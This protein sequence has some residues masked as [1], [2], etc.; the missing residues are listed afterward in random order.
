MQLSN[1]YLE[2][3]I[4]SKYDQELPQSQTNLW[5]HMEETQ[6]INSHTTARTQ[7]KAT[8]SLPQPGIILGWAWSILWENY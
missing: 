4:K 8:I 5:H 6:N 2:N 1:Q 3:K 7:S